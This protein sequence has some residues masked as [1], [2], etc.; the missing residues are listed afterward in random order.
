MTENVRRRLEDGGG[1]TRMEIRKEKQWREVKYWKKAESKGLLAM[2]LWKSKSSRS[3]GY[4][5][6]KPQ[7]AG[8]A[9]Q[10]PPLPSAVR[11]LRDTC[12][13]EVQR[14]W[15]AVFTSAKA[16]AGHY[17]SVVEGTCSHW[18]DLCTSSSS[19]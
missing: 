6:K 8:R 3:E 16:H 18:H 17:S 1:K 15:G 14:Q 4:T 9:I 7:C 10:H 12:E 13:K 19:A 11:P 2:R 5:H